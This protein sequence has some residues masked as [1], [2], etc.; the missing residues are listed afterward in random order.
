MEVS[1]CDRRKDV[2]E[3]DLECEK[4]RIVTLV[5]FSV[6]SGDY[7]LLSKFPL[8]TTPFPHNTVFSLLR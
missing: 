1:L 8:S 2:K 6:T 4:L 5:P 3:E 7:V